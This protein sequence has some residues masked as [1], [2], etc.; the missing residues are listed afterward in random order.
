RCGGEALAGEDRQS[1][2]SETDSHRAKH[3]LFVWGRGL[4]GPARSLA[5]R[6]AFSFAAIVCVVVGMV[7]A[8]LYHATNRALSTRADFQLIGRVEHFRSL[9]HDL[10]TI[11]EIE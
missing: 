3:W 6:I 9:L 11:N 8:A 4:K 1:V 5:V 7:G 2:Q 10:Y